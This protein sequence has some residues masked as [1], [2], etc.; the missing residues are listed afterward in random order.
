MEKLVRDVTMKVSRELHKLRLEVNPTRVLDENP[1]FK[2]LLPQVDCTSQEINA[3]PFLEHLKF[4]TSL[5]HT[6]ASPVSST[7]PPI[8]CHSY[9]SL[10]KSLTRPLLEEVPT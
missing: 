6:T 5:V 4:A 2:F 3:T 9:Y 10:T 8:K 1:V 7:E